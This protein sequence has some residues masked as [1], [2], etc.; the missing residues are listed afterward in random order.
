VRAVDLMSRTP[1]I[2][3]YTF[4]MAPDFGGKPW[5]LVHY[6]CLKSAIKHIRPERVNFYYEYEPRGPWWALTRELVTL[7][8][9]AAPRQSLGGAC[10]CFP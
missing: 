9:S 3:H 1:R 8:K 2:L 7:V 4:G 6:V 10:T 5:R